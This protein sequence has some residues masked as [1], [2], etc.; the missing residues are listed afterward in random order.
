MINFF[1]RYS[2]YNF[3]ASA[4]KSLFPKDTSLGLQD[5]NL[6]ALK[7]GHFC[8]NGAVGLSH[9]LTVG[10]RP[11]WNYQVYWVNIAPNHF[12][13]KSEICK[14]SRFTQNQFLLQLRGASRQKDSTELQQAYSM[15]CSGELLVSDY[16][17][18]FC[19]RDNSFGSAAGRFYSNLLSLT[20]INALQLSFTRPM[21]F[22]NA[23][24]L[25]LLLAL[26]AQ[27]F[28][29]ILWTPL[30]QTWNS[31]IHVRKL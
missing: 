30:N 10:R 6:Q 19:C 20:L 16:W 7:R 5:H 3:I 26:S 4:C 22:F 13:L 9:I 14:K 29:N 15:C 25:Y 17:T 31:D 28:Q 24:Q 23:Y 1:F 12:P 11:N 2:I 27:W 18:S 8:K 21:G